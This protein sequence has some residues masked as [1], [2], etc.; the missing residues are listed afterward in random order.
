[1]VIYYYTV[2]IAQKHF[3]Y[4]LYLQ[5]LTIFSIMF[6]MALSPEFHT[7]VVPVRSSSELSK[8]GLDINLFG[9]L[10]ISAAFLLSSGLNR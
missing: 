8:S 6:K 2:K 1:M 3:C 4:N 7:T 5:A 10:F 9:S